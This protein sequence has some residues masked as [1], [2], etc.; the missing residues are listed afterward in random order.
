MSIL[1]NRLR[2]LRTAGG[3]A[4]FTITAVVAATLPGISLTNAS[5]NDQEYDHGALGAENC[6]TATNF[7]TRGAGKLI[8]GSVGGIN[9]DT[10]ASV[11]GVVVNNG[12][13]GIG[14]FPS[15]ANSLGNDAYA[16][17]LQVS[18]L[19]TIDASLGTLLQLPTGQDAGVLNQYA[20]AHTNGSSAGASGLV[21]N[22]GG[23]ALTST[24]PSSGLP[25]FATVDL[26]SLLHAL[27]LD[28]LSGL[29]GLQL[30]LGAVASSASLSGCSAMW[31][32]DLYSNLHR[33]YGIAGLNTE[34]ES[35]LVAPL[36][37][38]LTDAISAL[39]GAVSGV[40]GN[41][42]VLS[43]ATSGVSGLVGGILGAVGVGTPTATV[44][45]SV[46]TSGLTAL[47]TNDI[48]DSQGI[49]DIDLVNGTITINTAALFNG[50]NGLNNLAPNT[51]L[52]I[53]STVINALKSAITTALS[54]YVTSIS[55]ALAAAITV[56][57]NVS[58][59]IAALGTG[60][61]ISVGANNISL[62]TLKSGN[63]P[64]TLS[65]TCTLPLPGAC[66]A[67]HLLIDGLLANVPAAVQGLIETPVAN[68]INGLLPGTVV[69]LLDNLNTASAGII[70]LLG[71]TLSG[72][73]GPDSVLSL[74][75]NAQNAPDPAQAVAGNPLPV[76]AASQPAPSVNPYKSGR[77]G[78]SAIELV[79]A[80]LISVDLAHSSVGS[81]NLTP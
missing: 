33:N 6:A 29:A 5:W 47:L 20:Q 81:N 19:G 69:H 14:V 65:S 41:A 62:S 32:R 44:T 45:A 42:G 8:G 43:A 4:G 71:G 40:A 60:G 55:N 35:P 16:N 53:N 23:V 72:L 39:P 26:T 67:E 79:V 28:G 48:T 24:K 61:S 58:V 22:S 68:A 66:D 59:P 34:I 74:V 54:D 78:V 51:Q 49:V 46:D 50:T 52:L 37:T 11:N 80:G 17:P 75:V 73:F 30:K 1:G 38:D 63:A 64:L 15:G 18:A 21:S 7:A 36:R 70:T 57:L 77:F 27:G 9:L 3:I 2:R 31:N 10:L 13:G 76:W 25:T 12:S 56:N